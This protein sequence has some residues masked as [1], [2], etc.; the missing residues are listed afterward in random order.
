MT[1]WNKIAVL[2]TVFMILSF[3]GI[4][5]V[6]PMVSDIKLIEKRYQLCLVKEINMLSCS[7]EYYSDV[8]SCLTYA[9]DNLMK[10]LNAPEKAVLER[11]QLLWLKKRNSE[12]KAIDQ[13]NSLEGR[14]GQMV[15][16]TQKA[17]F[18]KAR[19]FD[20]IRKRHN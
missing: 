9:Y 11:E 12:F 7:M 10:Q 4:G 2:I 18:V 16:Q 1:S 20:L 14:D 6:R 15:R 17:D 3:Q 19:A 13:A 8:D 5:Q